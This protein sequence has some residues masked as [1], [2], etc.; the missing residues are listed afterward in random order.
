MDAS[1]TSQCKELE[2]KVGGPMKLAEITGARA[3]ERYTGNQIMKICQQ[4]RQAY[5]N[6]ERISLV[7]SF[8]A[9]LFLGDY[10]PIDYSDGSG[11]NLL[12]INT[13]T[14]SS[15]CLE[16]CGP[17]LGDKLGEPDSPRK[18]LGNISP[19]FVKKY[20]FPEFCKVVAFT[21]DNPGQFL[22]K[23]PENFLRSQEPYVSL[24]TSDTVFFWLSHQKPGL[25]G[26]IFVNPIAPAAYMA[27]VCFKNGSLTRERIM[28][29]CA[30]SWDEFSKMLKDTPIGN[31]G[32][33]GIYFDVMEIQ[34]LAEGVHRF[35]SSD[36]S[37]SRF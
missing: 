21:G 15:Q 18:T 31:N 36:E 34:P 10:A 32:N 2:A 17:G 28:D 20:N 6:T 35:N 37:V 19:Y 3:F 14:W 7:S 1:T 22:S 8:A 25:E 23:F 4:N 26:H 11:M 33:I 9:S 13:K 5:D 29:K 24:G 16:A 27:L 30:G 12:D